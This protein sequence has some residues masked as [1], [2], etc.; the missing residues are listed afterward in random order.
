MTAATI[1]VAVL[2][3]EGVG[4]V[5]LLPDGVCCDLPEHQHALRLTQ[6]L[7]HLAV[8]AGGSQCTGWGEAASRVRY[9]PSTQSEHG[10]L[11]VQSHTC[12][13]K[14]AVK[15]NRAVKQGLQ[16]GAREVDCANSLRVLGQHRLEAQQD[17][18]HSL[19]EL[20]LV[21][22]PCPD[23][24]QD[25]L[26]PC[27]ENTVSEGGSET[28]DLLDLAV[29]PNSC[30]QADSNVYHVAHGSE[31]GPKRLPARVLRSA[32]RTTCPSAVNANNPGCWGKTCAHLHKGRHVQLGSGSG[33]HINGGNSSSHVEVQLLVCRES[34]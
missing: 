19:Q 2:Q 9:R 14:H 33:T 10:L 29:A 31:A 20:I 23:L 25:A 34:C 13:H 27:N 3:V 1:T 8:P 5:G 24:G 30:N 7:Q 11:V 15:L 28:R 26:Q 18:L 12:I 21:G 16:E 4:G 22:V 17:L 32:R 6:A